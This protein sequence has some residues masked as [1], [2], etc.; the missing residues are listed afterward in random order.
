MLLV[1]DMAND[2][3]VLV[4]SCDKYH[5]LWKPFFTLFFRYWQDCP[6]PIYLGSNHSVYND[7]R[8]KTITVGDDIDWSHSFRRM[9]EHIPH[10]YVII[11][12]EDYLV[13][14][15]VDTDRL[16]KLV[17]YLKDKKAACLRI[18]PCPGPH[19]IRLD[20]K[21]VG[22]IRK[23][24][25]Y[26]LSLQSAIW[27]KQSLIQDGETPWQFEVKGSIRTNQMDKLFLS[28]IREIPPPITYFCTAVL[29]GKWLRDAVDL[30]RKEGIEVDLS[31]RPCETSFDRGRNFVM[32]DILGRSLTF[33]SKWG[34]KRH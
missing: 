10:K 15:H 29:K 9:L 1:N 20:N 32:H 30:C 2:V 22:I 8:V 21:E 26:R 13:Y 11:L 5:D 28:I 18:F 34:L 25:E 12:L 23:G 3:A 6:Y 31:I 17:Y 27:D 4:V 14:K 33:L 7:S 19:E 16:N 24:A